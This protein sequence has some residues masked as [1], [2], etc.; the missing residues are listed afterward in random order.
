MQLFLNGSGTY[1][2]TFLWKNTHLPE[3]WCGT[4]SMKCL[5]KNKHLRGNKSST[6]NKEFLLKYN[7]CLQIGLVTIIRNFYARCFEI[8]LVPMIWNFNL[9]RIIYVSHL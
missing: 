5:W 3:D 8:G 9:K 2:M 6:Y 4:N 1:N 7:I